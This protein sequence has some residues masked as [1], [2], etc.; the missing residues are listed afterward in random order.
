MNRPS[1]PKKLAALSQSQYHESTHWYS[2][3]QYTPINTGCD[4]PIDV[5]S[6]GDIQVLKQNV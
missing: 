2:R 4:P 5:R 6:V 3:W 1:R